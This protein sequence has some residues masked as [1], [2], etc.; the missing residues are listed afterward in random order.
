MLENFFSNELIVAH[1][2]TALI[3]KVFPFWKATPLEAGFGMDELNFG[4][5]LLLDPKPWGQDSSLWSS[6]PVSSF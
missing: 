1:N 3:S 5:I 6:W 4:N 2:F